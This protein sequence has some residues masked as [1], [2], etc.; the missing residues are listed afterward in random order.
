[1]HARLGGRGQ[2]TDSPIAVS[3]APVPRPYEVRH[4]PLNGAVVSSLALSKNG[5][6][7]AGA[8]GET[9]RL[10]DMTTGKV[11]LPFEGHLDGVLALAFQPDGRMMAST[12]GKAILLWDWRREKMIR[13][14]VGAGQQIRS[15]AC[16]AF[17]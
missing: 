15:L 4:F 6:L 2:E 9:I 16:S 14:L 12:D 1:L 11:V 13:P 5:K 17:S 8:A 10:W 7:L 3:T